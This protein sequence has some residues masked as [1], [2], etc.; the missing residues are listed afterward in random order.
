MCPNDTPTTVT[1]LGIPPGSVDE[2]VLLRLAQEPY[3]TRT[4]DLDDLGVKRYVLTVLLLRM[5]QAKL[6]ARNHPEGRR[7]LWSLTSQGR[8]L[9]AAH[10]RAHRELFT[11]EEAMAAGAQAP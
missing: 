7:P 6:V 11:M 5:K 9:L 10:V 2:A 8:A 3:G 4:H 1:D